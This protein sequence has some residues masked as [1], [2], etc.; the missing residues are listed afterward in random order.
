MPVDLVWGSPVED[1]E[2]TQISDEYVDRVKE[3]TEAAYEFARKHR[4]VAAGR[5]KNTYVVRV[6]ENTFSIGDWVWYYYPRRYQ[7]R[8]PKWQK[9]Y[10]GPYLIT[11][12]QLRF[13]KVA[14]GKTICGACR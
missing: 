10:T 13:A 6:K 14:E 3:N 7:R 1:N 2:T 9:L 8:S 11:T 12:C 4:Q 5:C